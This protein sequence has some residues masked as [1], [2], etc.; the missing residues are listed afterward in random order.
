MPYFHAQRAMG[1]GIAFIILGAIFGWMVGCIP[2]LPVATLLRPQLHITLR[3][4]ISLALSTV[5]LLLI[6]WA[7]VGL[8]NGKLFALY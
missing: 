3:L 5:A 2:F 8:H 1:G 4:L 7:S 6:I